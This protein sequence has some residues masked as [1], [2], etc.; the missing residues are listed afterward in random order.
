MFST[1]LIILSGQR[2]LRRGGRRAVYAVP[3]KPELLIKVDTKEHNK[4]PLPLLKRVIRWLFPLTHH[5]DK[6]IEAKCEIA[7][8]LK[9]GPKAEE[10]PLP[11]FFGIAATDL[12]SGSVIEKIVDQNGNIATTFYVLC[13]KG[14]ITDHLIGLLNELVG[15]I[16]D[17]HIDCND[18]HEGNIVLGY[19]N[20]K[21][22]LFLIDGYGDRNIIPLRAWVR[23]INNNRLDNQC[24][25]MADSA[26]FVWN[27][28]Q[29]KFS[30]P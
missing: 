19:R 15:K 30:L 20:G 24:Q 9:L 6:I 11:K 21:E 27:K 29:R 23:I 14:I 5:R 26:N 17:L 28:A 18:I 4:K 25:K 12:G 3:G 2:P 13:K 8:A 1:E 16:Y 22:A 10:S 7:T